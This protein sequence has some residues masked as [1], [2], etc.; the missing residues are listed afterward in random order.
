MGKEPLKVLSL[1][2]NDLNELAGELQ[3]NLDRE[4]IVFY[5]E[6]FP[7]NEN[8]IIKAI[9]TVDPDIAFLPFDDG[10]VVVIDKEKILGMVVPLDFSD[11]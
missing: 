8:T 2:G 3:K 10:R 4:V 5:I 1:L 9:K 7:V 6:A 11:N